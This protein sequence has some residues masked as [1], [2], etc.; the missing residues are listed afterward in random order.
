MVLVEAIIKRRNPLK[1]DSKNRTG[2]PK[3]VQFRRMN[4]KEKD[5]RAPKGTQFL[6]H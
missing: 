3:R 6:R 5:K 2:S 4:P 1:E